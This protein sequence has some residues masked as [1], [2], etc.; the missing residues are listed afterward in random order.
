MALASFWETALKCQRLS[1]ALQQAVSRAPRQGDVGR[2]Q[3]IDVLPATDPPHPAL[4]PPNPA[5]ASGS[6][7]RETRPK[8][9]RRTTNSQCAE[10]M[11]ETIGRLRRLSLYLQFDV[12]GPTGKGGRG[13][14]PFT[15]S[16]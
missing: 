15:W 9:A 4:A 12:A 11:V 16:T 8:R 5:A 3:H 6:A 1:V 2:D 14:A 13:G 7:E 10:R